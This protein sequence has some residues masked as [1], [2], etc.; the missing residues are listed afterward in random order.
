M[1]NYT[2]PN[3]GVNDHA[4]LKGVARNQ[5]L[6]GLTN[7]ESGTKSPGSGDSTVTV[8][9]SQPYLICGYSGSEVSTGS[10]FDEDAAVDS[11]TTDANGN[12]DGLVIR[13]DFDSSTS[14]I[15]WTVAGIPA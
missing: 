11:V 2:H 7:T 13:Y 14:T 10:D 4:N 5:H 1:A 9:F 12:V 8:S 3:P 15:Y 6:G